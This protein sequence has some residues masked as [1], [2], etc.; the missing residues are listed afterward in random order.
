MPKPRRARAAAPH[1][2]IASLSR[3]ALSLAGLSVLSAASAASYLVQPG[4]TLYGLSKR[5]GCSIEELA[6]AAGPQGL[7]AGQVLQTARPI[8][9]AGAVSITPQSAQ[10][11]LDALLRAAGVTPAASPV[12]QPVAG[13]A[14]A[15]FPLGQ[16]RP[17]E[18]K[19][20]PSTARYTMM[21]SGR[22]SAQIRAA[23]TG[24]SD[25]ILGG[26]SF[27]FQRL[28]ACG[29]QSV[30]SVLSWFGVNQTQ[31]QVAKKIQVPGK[32][33]S[34]SGMQLGFESA[35]LRFRSLNGARLSQ[36]RALSN[37]GIPSI[38]LQKLAQPS[39]ID[40]FRVIR[41]VSGG[42]VHLLDPYYGAHVSLSVN[43]FEQ[44]WGN[45][46]TLLIGYPASLQPVVDAALRS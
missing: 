17:A 4:D 32:Y 10:R 14:P 3:A 29:P 37:A 15:P 46:R 23:G 2:L 30:S 24:S 20:R 1:S 26:M 28:N 36:V 25:Q 39:A 38:A 31:D 19:P 42:E 11:D 8:A 40:H 44:L 6:Q 21:P 22:Q 9:P 41:G 35:G 27:Q 7:R 43:E 16:A 33:T 13:A 34:I 12:P 18:F 45:R 5:C